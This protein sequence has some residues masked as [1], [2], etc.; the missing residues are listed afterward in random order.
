MSPKIQSKYRGDGRLC[1]ILS[2]FGAKKAILIVT[3]WTSSFVVLRV[4]KALATLLC[5]G[6]IQNFRKLFN[7]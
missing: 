2:V 1:W 3:I 4:E 6:F 7:R 5:K